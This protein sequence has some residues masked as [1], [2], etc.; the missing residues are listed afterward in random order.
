MGFHTE[1][2]QH[3]TLMGTQKCVDVPSNFHE[4]SMIM[5]KIDGKSIRFEVTHQTDM[6][7]KFVVEPPL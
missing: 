2:A 4:N 7:G 5:M 1:F 6:L 3:V